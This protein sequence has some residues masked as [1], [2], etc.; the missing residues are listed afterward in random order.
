MFSEFHTAATLTLRL[1]PKLWPLQVYFFIVRCCLFVVVVDVYVLYV[2]VYCVCVC[3]VCMYVCGVCMYICVFVVCV[4]C[5]YVCMCVVI[6]WH[7]K[8][9]EQHSKGTAA[10]RVLTIA[11]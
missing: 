7:L 4:L 6:G 10:Q 9:K 3:C 5:V 8:V 11:E 2:F 1:H